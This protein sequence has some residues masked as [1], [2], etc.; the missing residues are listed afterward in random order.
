MIPNLDR[1]WKAGVRGLVVNVSLTNYLV[2]A[3]AWETLRMGV[4][5]A[6]DLGFRIWIYDEE[7]YPSGAAGLRVLQQY[8]EGEAKG[9][10][11]HVDTDGAPRYEV[12]R[13]YE[14]THAT[15]NFYAKRPYI[16]ILDQTAVSAFV[17]VT[18][19]RYAAVLD[20]LAAYVE[21]FFTD[22]PSLIACYVPQGRDYPLT[23]PWHPGVPEAFRLRK[24]YDLIPHLESLFRTTGQIDRQIRCDFY[25][26]IAHLCAESFFGT[27]QRWCRNRGVASSGHLLGEETMFWQTVFEGDPFPCYERFDIPGIDMILSDPERIMREKFFLVPKIAG[28]AARIKG[29][30]RVMCEISDFLGVFGKHP[31]SPAQTRCTAAILYA[32]G[33]TDLVSMYPSPA[34]PPSTE[35]A[36][37][38]SP[39]STSVDEQLRGYADYA[40]RLHSLFVQGRVAPK[41][42]V[43]HPLVS[44]WAHFVP[45]H[46]S[47]YEPHPD[48]TVRL[49]DED[50]ADLCR[51]LLQ[52]QVEFDIIDE[53]SVSE[54][55]VEGNQLVIG[56]ARYSVLL[57]PSMDTIRVKTAAALKRFAEGGGAVLMRPLAPQFAAEGPAH[58]DDIRCATEILRRACGEQHPAWP[59]GEQLR[60]LHLPHCEIIPPSP[61]ILC[62]QLQTDER[63]L[64]FLIN[65]SH[66]PYHGRMTVTC[67]G[68][69][70]LLHPGDGT[71]EE[72]QVRAGTDSSTT[73]PLQL[74][75]F[76]SIFAEFRL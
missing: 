7:G 17:Q 25:D 37:S 29:K 10:I 54:A 36:D 20:P 57:L 13:L 11:R 60:A 51:F 38:T 73:L 28:S 14:G 15:E 2:D 1:M 48:P 68:R 35:A 22:E 21:A 67:T 58:D 56:Q 9:L 62:T 76:E 19:E 50:F 26:V 40:A 6:H 34:S 45:S 63:A 74:T 31:A 12:V 24:G 5:V 33:V 69:V 49:I 61:H 59:T 70:F 66:T 42:A 72:A 4:H 75:S 3:A 39:S 52:H 23:L 16:N 65:T 18:H 46:R 44:V 71:E 32:F 43:L 8:P 55:Q 41:L 27:I 53:A 47:M 64:F 30:G